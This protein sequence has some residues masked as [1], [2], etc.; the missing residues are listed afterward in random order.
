MKLVNSLIST[1]RQAKSCGTSFDVNHSSHNR[2]KI[3]TQVSRRFRHFV[4]ACVHSQI[5]DVNVF[6]SFWLS[7]PFFRMKPGAM[8]SVTYI[9]YIH[10]LE[11]PPWAHDST[12]YIYVN[13]IVLDC[14]F[15]SSR[16]SFWIDLI[17]GIC[18]NDQSHST[19][20][21]PYTYPE[22]QPWKDVDP[23]SLANS[24][25]TQGWCLVQLFNAEHPISQPQTK[26]KP[27]PPFA[28]CL[29]FARYHQQSIS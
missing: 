22:F 27:F 10:R 2:S 28:L 12:H 17:F 15:V 13:R 3:K 8:A 14:A 11:L 24:L 26:P 16:L 1:Y 5:R 18:H 21:P 4:I 25:L 19:M 9:T 29:H 23:K 20:F 6:Q 7:L